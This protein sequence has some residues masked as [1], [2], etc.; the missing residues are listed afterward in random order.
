MGPGFN[1]VCV[2]R[3]RRAE[4]QIRPS[5]EGG[6]KIERE[7]GGGGEKKGETGGGRPQLSDEINSAPGL[8]PGS[9]HPSI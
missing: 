3:E 4:L 5:R 8:V 7:R 6:R 9:S 2:V 1:A